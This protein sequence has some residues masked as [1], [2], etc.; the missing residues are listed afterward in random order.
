MQSC[1]EPLRQHCIRFLLVQCCP[2]SIKTT[3]HRIF[4]CA[5]LSGASRATLLRVFGCEILSQEYYANIAQDFFLCLESLGQHC[6][7][8]LTLQCRPKSIKTTLHRIF[9]YTKL[10]G[11]SRATLHR[12]SICAMLSKEYY[13]NIA[14]DFFLYKVVW[15]IS[16][17]IAQGFQLCNVVQRVLRQHCTRFFLMQCCLKPLG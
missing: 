3:L 10:P 2:K 16:G 4:S 14:Q 12:V 5:M 15:S 1:L 11:A 9:S 17:N 8:F 6:I 7:G 13:N